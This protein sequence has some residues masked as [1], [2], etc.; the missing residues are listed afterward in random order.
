[1]LTW[2]EFAA[3]VSIALGLFSSGVWAVYRVCWCVDR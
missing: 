3:Y 2:T 1:M